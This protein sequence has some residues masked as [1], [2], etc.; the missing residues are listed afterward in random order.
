MKVAI[1][2]E[3]KGDR[4]F[5]E[6]FIKH[7]K[8]ETKPNFYTLSGKSN[9]LDPTHTKYQELKIV[10][11]AE[12]H[13]LLFVVDADDVKNDTRHGG[14]ENTQQTLNQ[15]IAEL[16]LGEVSNTYIMCDPMTKIGYLESL[17]LSTIPEHQKNCIQSFLE[18]SEF[19]SKE[20]HKT[21]LNSIYKTAY[22]NTPYDF[23]HPHF[24][25]LKNKLSSLFAS[26]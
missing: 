3:G 11:A 14:F 2:C 10:V 13:K 8:I 25:E 21:I 4:G 23:A 6:E 15:V 19:K 5:L 12:P 7:L 1:I 24:D 16:E 17:I 18:C 20:N 22:P 9:L 26:E